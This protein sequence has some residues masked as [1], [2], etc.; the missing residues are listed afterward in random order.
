MQVRF[1]EDARCRQLETS[2]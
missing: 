1:S 2:A